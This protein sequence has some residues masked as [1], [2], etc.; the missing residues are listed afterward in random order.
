MRRGLDTRFTA[1]K[2]L[3]VATGTQR[4]QGDW[5]EEVPSA[6]EKHTSAGAVGAEAREDSV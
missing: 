4:R 2:T 3:A 1:A 6:F 5:L